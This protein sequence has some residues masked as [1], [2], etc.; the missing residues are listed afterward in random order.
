MKPALLVIDIQNAYL[1]SIPQRDKEVGMYMINQ[2]IGLF[3][4]HG[5]PIIRIY[6]EDLKEGPHS[7]TE[8]FEYPSIIQVSP[9]DP[10]IIKHYNDSF[11]KT[12]L[13]KLLNDHGVDVLFLCG[14]SAVYCVLSTFVGARNHDYKAFMIKDAI[15]SHNSNYTDTIEDIYGAV[16]L[17]LVQFILDNSL[18]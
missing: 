12:E 11:N 17:E 9:N 13:A 3:R 18:K 7:N 6:H 5:F 15:M 8:A 16:N 1:P 14:L 2:A 4:K 10:M